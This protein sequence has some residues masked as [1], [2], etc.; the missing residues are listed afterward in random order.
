MAND[1]ELTWVSGKEHFSIRVEELLGHH[2]NTHDSQKSRF[3]IFGFRSEKHAESFA[4]ILRNSLFDNIVCP[5]FFAIRFYLEVAGKKDDRILHEYSE[6][7]GVKESVKDIMDNISA[8]KFKHYKGPVP[9]FEDSI[10]DHSLIGEKPGPVTSRAISKNVDCPYQIMHS[11]DPIFTILD[12]GVKLTISLKSKNDDWPPET[13]PS[14]WLS[15]LNKNPTIRSVNSFFQN[16]PGFVLSKFNFKDD[17][18]SSMST[19]VAYFDVGTNG[20]L[21]PLEALV[22]ARKF[23]CYDN[24]DYAQCYSITEYEEKLGLNDEVGYIDLREVEKQDNLVLTA[25]VDVKMGTKE[26][27]VE[28]SPKE[29]ELG[30]HSIG[31][32]ELGISTRAYNCLKCAQ[33]NTVEDLL[34][35]SNENLRSIKNFGVKS[36]QEVIEA[37]QNKHGITLPD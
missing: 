20:S 3:R 16:E 23:I 24:M 32:E 33:I 31:V 10:S 13:L 2:T 17:A 25:N 8:L 27:T 37:L 35:Y 14:G 12:P 34:D 1:R 28:K 21:T 26:S 19:L 6:I 11:D 22:L 7:P 18:L 5:S 29:T 30:L 4:I 36:V 9:D 15:I